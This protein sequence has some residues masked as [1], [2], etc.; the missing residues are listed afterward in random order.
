MSTETQPKAAQ[1]SPIDR[2]TS[3]LRHT[4][5]IRSARGGITAQCPAHHDTENSLMIWEDESDQHVGVMCFAGCSRSAICTA[6]GITESDLYVQDGTSKRPK[7]PGLSLIDLCKEKWIHPR[8]L[9]IM[10]LGIA[11]TIMYENRQ[12]IRIP[13]YRMDGTEHTR[14]R[15]RTD[16]LAKKGSKWGL[17]CSGTKKW[18]KEKLNLFLFL[19]SAR[20]EGERDP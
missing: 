13:Y 3:L 2:I 7:K 12:A 18:S 9:E 6:W 16:I 11:D 8:D 10:Q 15:I 20:Q 5:S 17:R 19:P 14:Y 1:Q 4:R